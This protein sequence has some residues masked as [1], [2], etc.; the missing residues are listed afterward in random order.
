MTSEDIVR[1]VKSAVVLLLSV[2]VVAGLLA[3][4]KSDAFIP[5]LREN[6]MSAASATLVVTFMYQLLA[7][8]SNKI[9]VPTEDPSLASGIIG[10]KNST[11][12]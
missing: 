9:T 3:V 11:L 7:A 2:G 1:R 4:V 8:L 6:G 10:R 12:I 5:F